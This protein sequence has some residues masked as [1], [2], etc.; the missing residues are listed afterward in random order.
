MKYCNSVSLHRS[1]PHP[2]WRQTCPQPLGGPGP[3]PSRDPAQ[4]PAQCVLGRHCPPPGPHCSSSAVLGRVWAEESPGLG[5]QRPGP[6]GFP[7]HATQGAESEESS[8]PP[9]P[10]CG[11]VSQALARR[12]PRICVC[13]SVSEAGCLGA[14]PVPLG[15]AWAGTAA[16]LGVGLPGAG[17]EGCRGEGSTRKRRTEKQ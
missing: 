11:F 1:A 9:I 14:N 15:S 4:G 2:S 6:T 13:S 3:A 5:A 10:S 12:T 16:Q 17:A 7:T 8:R